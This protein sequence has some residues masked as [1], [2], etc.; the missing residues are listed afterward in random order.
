MS[1]AAAT[2]VVVTGPISGGAH[3]WPFGAAVRDL[4][5]EGYV[6]EEYFFEGD[7]QRYRPTGELGVDGRSDAE[8]TTTGSFKTRAL[9]RRPADP[10]RFNGT[11]IVEWN[12]V[13]AGCEIFEAGDTSVVF[14][15]GFA[16]VGVSAQ[17]VGVHGQGT[18]P[19]GL[20][21]WDPERYGS[22]DI[23]DDALSYGIF[24]AVARALS[25]SRAGGSVDPLRGLPVQ[26]LL[27]A[28]GS[29]SA[30]R[31]AT[32]INAIQP[33]ERVFDA[34]VLFTWFGSGM[35]IDDPATFDINTGGRA[36]IVAYPTR[37]RA[38]L[39]VPVMVVNSECET[40]SVLPVRQP[41]TDR[42][43]FWE[44]AGAPHGPRLHMER[45]AGKMQRDGIGL[46][47]APG[48]PA[49]DLTSLG[50]V[51][52]AGVLDAGLAHTHAWMAHGEPPPVQPLVE[53]EG[54][55]PRIRRDADGN[56][57]GG[58]RLPE[59]DVT[60]TRNVGAIEEAGAAGL[61]GITT[62]LPIE[63]VHDRYPDLDRYLAAFR[64]AADRA[65]AAG[66]LRRRD[67]D[68]AIERAKTVTL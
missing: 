19:Q 50:P 14:D 62:P 22:L 39:D 18:D 44:V 20:R 63:V 52:F 21:A 57:V 26:R 17:R 65:V 31:L 66:V 12:N 58:L 3:G 51:P 61:M 38:D 5:R 54:D 1:D 13:S 68:E 36:Q 9:V 8:P 28:G 2:D 25:A 34:F 16:Y 43:R 6:E 59:M 23:A 30:G 42:F 46:P 60:L 56:A 33:L 29:Q 47:S 15:E 53:I 64:A 40:L 11:V 45:I 55:P 32:Y 48:A 4:V 41:D 7:A 37:I 24:T 35:S 10:A 49:I 27:A 67:A